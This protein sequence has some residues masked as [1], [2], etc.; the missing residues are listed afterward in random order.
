MEG[1]TTIMYIYLDAYEE[2]MVTFYFISCVI[3]CSF[4]LLNLTIAVMLMEY[5]QLDKTEDKSSHKDQ[6]RN[7]GEDSGLP[8][9]LIN[10]II[11]QNNI[12]ISK[13]ATKLL[14][15]KH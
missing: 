15:P 9:P 13:K 11:T 6:L 1:W 10:F 7:L 4:F 2:A 12:S 3:V 5:E 8:Q 14:K